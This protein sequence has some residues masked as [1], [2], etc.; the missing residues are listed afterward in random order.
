MS[1]PGSPRELA[2]ERI[3]LTPTV[4]ADGPAL[5]AIHSA[6]EVAEWWELPDPGFPM[7]DEPETTRFTIRN[8]EEIVGLIQYGEESEPKY[9][10]A[11][12]DIFVAPAS[13]TQGIGTEALALLVDHLIQDRGHHRVTIDPATENLAAVECYRKAGFAPVGV[14]RKAERDTGGPGWHDVLFMELVV[15]PG[16]RKP[17]PGGRSPIR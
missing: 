12:I 11:W 7:H 4:E 3:R 2:G 13:H 8:G 1:D 6:P 10:H 15:D 16:E 5:T 17:R 14:L 9:R